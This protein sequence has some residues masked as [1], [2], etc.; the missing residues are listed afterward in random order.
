MHWCALAREQ[1]KEGARIGAAAARQAAARKHAQEV[2]AAKKRAKEAK[3]EE[4]KHQKAILA[5]KLKLAARQ[6]ALAHAPFPAT[7]MKETTREYVKPTTVTVHAHLT[8][9]LVFTIPLQRKKNI[10]SM[11]TEIERHD[12]KIQ[13]G[14]LHT[15]EKFDKGETILLFEGSKSPQTRYFPH[16]HTLHTSTYRLR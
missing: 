11:I 6:T 13:D 5:K 12:L 15:T 8:H 7:T 1:Q 3:K 4:A 14:K 2:K 16:T 9:F 10:R